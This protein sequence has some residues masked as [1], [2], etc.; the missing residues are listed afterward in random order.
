M[1]DQ[2]LVT[3]IIERAGQEEDRREGLPVGEVERLI[4]SMEG[5]RDATVSVQLTEL[6][7]RAFVAVDAGH[8]FIGL[9]RSDGVFQFA[10]RNAGLTR[11]PF[12]IGGQETD[13]EVRYLVNIDTAAAIVREWL[14][15]G[16]ESS[17][18]SWERQ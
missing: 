5:E 7:E 2:Q 10:R 12:T 4:M 18:G 6:E 1:S 8:A 15:N 11:T 17:I 3:V 9:E 13:I 16:E 14:R